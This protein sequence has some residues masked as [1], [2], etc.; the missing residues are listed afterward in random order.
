LA[1]AGSVSMHDPFFRNRNNLDSAIHGNGA[2]R[3]KKSLFSQNPWIH[4]RS[5]V[6]H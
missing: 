4:G 6:S 3:P 5:A 2:I 1:Y